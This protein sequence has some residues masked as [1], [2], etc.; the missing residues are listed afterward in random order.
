MKKAHLTLI[1]AAII[2]SGCSGREETAEENAGK[3]LN[4]YFKAD[5]DGA[6]EFC[7]EE[8]SEI[9]RKGKEEIEK[10]D[11]SVIAIFKRELERLDVNING[12]SLKGDTATVKY[13]IID[14]AD[15]SAR[16]NSLKLRNVDGKWVVFSLN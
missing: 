15:S 14:K 4:C 5:L 6:S 12:T 3:F 2:L 8:I 7:T 1:A 11:S 13:T 10:K 9:L 16:E